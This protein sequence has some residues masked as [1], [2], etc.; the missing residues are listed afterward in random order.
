MSICFT[1][2][3]QVQIRAGDES[4]VL[5]YSEMG[6]EDHGGK[7]KT[8]P[9]QNWDVLRRFAKFNGQIRTTENA[10]EWGLVEK[11]VQTIN[12][13]LRRLFQLQAN[14]IHY[15][16]TAKCYKVAFKIEFRDSD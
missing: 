10:K 5:N 12:K 1:G 8:K 14:P 6:F 3:H 4:E 16:R 7:R 15:D 9:D 11:A 2:D 13:R